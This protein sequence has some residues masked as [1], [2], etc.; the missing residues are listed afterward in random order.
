MFESFVI[1]TKK[2]D[3]VRKFSAFRMLIKSQLRH[4]ANNFASLQTGK[5]PEE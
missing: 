4:L 1:N 3:G 2:E 5:K